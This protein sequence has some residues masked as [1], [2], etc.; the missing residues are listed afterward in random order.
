MSGSVLLTFLS[1][2]SLGLAELQ[3]NCNKRVFP[4]PLRASSGRGWYRFEKLDL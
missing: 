3:Q 1:S 4:S 2:G